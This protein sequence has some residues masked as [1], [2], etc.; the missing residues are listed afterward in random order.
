MRLHRLL[1]VTMLFLFFAFA[2]SGCAG[3]SYIRATASD[4]PLDKVEQ[5]AQKDWTVERVDENTLHLSNTWPIHSIAA[6]GYS[7]SYANLNYDASMSELDLQYYFK[8]SQLLLLFI[9]FSTDA[10]PGFVGGLLKPIMNQQIDDIIKWGNATITSRRSGSRFE[11]FPQD[12][13][14]KQNTEPPKEGAESIK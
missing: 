4:N 2:V 10:E 1:L 5:Q 3:A 11:I 9:P 7:A 6:L 14:K 12:K 8:S 13:N